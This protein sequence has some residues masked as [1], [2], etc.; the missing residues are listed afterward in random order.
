MET[1]KVQ[2]NISTQKSVNK[3]KKRDS[4][5][6]SESSNFSA[7]FLSTSQELSNKHE[8]SHK[9][10]TIELMM[11]TSS[12]SR[13]IERLTSTVEQLGVDVN[14]HKDVLKQTKLEIEQLKK[15]NHML[16]AEVT[17]NKRYSQG[18]F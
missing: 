13:R 10:S 4:K 3:R 17:E 11:E 9:I 5:D 8:T 1:F 14:C 12:T 2:T 7:D 18:R 6:N 15:E 16:R